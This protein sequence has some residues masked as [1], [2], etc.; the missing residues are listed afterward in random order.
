M[1]YIVYRQH[2]NFLMGGQFLGFATL[3]GC[4]NDTNGYYTVYRDASH[5]VKVYSS[6]NTN[7]MMN[8][9]HLILHKQLV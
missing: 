3:G 2:K 9:Y 5:W 1:I 4:L 6:N 7:S 8:L